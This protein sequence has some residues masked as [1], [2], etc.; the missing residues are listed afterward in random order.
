MLDKA[1]LVNATGAVSAQS[2][3]RPGDVP[4]NAI[5]IAGTMDGAVVTLNT[6]C[7]VTHEVSELDGCNWAEAKTYPLQL[8]KGL[9]LYISVA[10]GAGA[11][12]ITVTVR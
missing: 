8:P 1:L 7:P 10:G 4:L 5:T 3:G 6:K 12:D 11:Q 2:L 9:D